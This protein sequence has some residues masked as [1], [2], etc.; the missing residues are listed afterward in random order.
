[1]GKYIKG[2]IIRI[3]IDLRDNNRFVYIEI[4]KVTKTLYKYVI[5]HDKDNLC[6]KGLD[7]QTSIMEFD[8]YSNV[9]KIDDKEKEVLMA[10]LL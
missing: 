8:R 2:D 3:D 6:A 4:T 5:V 9:Y 1:M 7:Y 10:R